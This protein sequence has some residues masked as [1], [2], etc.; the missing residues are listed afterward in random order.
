MRSDNDNKILQWQQFLWVLSVNTDLWPSTWSVPRSDIRLHSGLVPALASGRPHSCLASLP[1]SVSGP[2]LLRRHKAERGG[3]HGNLPGSAHIAIRRWLSAVMSDWS[4]D[5]SPL[6]TWW[7]RN[8]GSTLSVSA[9]KRLWRP[10]PTC[11]SSTATRSSTLRRSLTS[12]H[13]QNA[14]RQVNKSVATYTIRRTSALIETEM[15]A[16]SRGSYSQL[17]CCSSYIIAVLCR[18]V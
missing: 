13:W 14:W 18:S 1:V 3:Y 4:H 12:A 9:V 10:S 7:Q 2:P 5:L 8:V 6:R 17:L 15:E 16:E 11:H